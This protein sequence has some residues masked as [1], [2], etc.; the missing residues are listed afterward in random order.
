MDRFTEKKRSL[1]FG[2]P[3]SFTTYII[4]EELLRKKEG[5]LSLKEND[6]YL[7]KIQDVTLQRSLIERL[8]GLSTIVCHT[9]DTTDPVLAL[10]HIRNGEEIKKYLV[11]VSD[12]ERLKRRTINTL[13]ITADNIDDDL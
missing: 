10:S 2:L 1:L 12:E 11:K 13:N 5:F 3:L 4:D 8:F 6:C 7:Y 9:G